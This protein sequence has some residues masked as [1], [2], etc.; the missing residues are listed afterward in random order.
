MPPYT[1]EQA[2]RM[3]SASFVPGETG[4][5]QERGATAH[6]M[7]LDDR[8]APFLEDAEGG[9]AQGHE[10]SITIADFGLDGGDTAR[11]VDDLGGAGD[12]T[13]PH[14]AEEVHVEADSRRPQAD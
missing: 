12:P 4:D 5:S 13:L 3:E 2:P 14:G 8:V 11:A 1:R 6:L 7:P 10:V 9:R